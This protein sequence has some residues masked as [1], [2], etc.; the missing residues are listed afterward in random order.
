MKNVSLPALKPFDYVSCG[1]GLVGTVLVSGFVRV[2]NP[3]I[4]FLGIA[5]ALLCLSSVGPLAIHLFSRILEPDE[6][7]LYTLHAGANLVP[8]LY[9][10]AHL[11]ETP[12]GKFTF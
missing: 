4:V 7:K 6:Q 11:T 2:P 5:S 1:I 10:L 12:W 8:T 3:I 9:F